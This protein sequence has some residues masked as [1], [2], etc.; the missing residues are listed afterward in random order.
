MRAS[1]S[2][3][4]IR[5]GVARFAVVLV[6]S[7]AL[8]AR[9][10]QFFAPAYNQPN[11]T[12]GGQIVHEKIPYQPSQLLVPTAA[13]ETPVYLDELAEPLE[14]PVLIDPSCDISCLVCEERAAGP[15]PQL[16]PGV[17]PGIFQKLFFTGA[18]QP[19]LEND[20][21]GWGDLETGIVLGLP[22]LRR[23]TPLVITPRFAVY[24]LD[25]PWMP[26]LPERLYDAEV[27]FR[28]LRRF[29]QGPWAMNVAVTLGHYSDWEASDADAFRVTGDAFAVY[30]Q[31]PGKKWV[32]GVIYL[33]REDIA[34]IPAA[35][36]IYEP[37]PDVKYEAILPRP[38]IAWRLPQTNPQPGDAR[39]FY[40]GGEFGSGIWSIERPLSLTQDLLTYRDLRV[41][42]GYERKVVGGL[43]R[44]FETGYV[45]DRELEF[46]SATPRLK[47]GDT[48]I[49]RV[50]V[51]Y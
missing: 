31:G 7:S 49:L 25:R 33:N 13:A 6:I 40:V 42:I 3:A 21:L 11:P 45:F 8:S 18:W 12:W 24:F 34:V 19:Q 28:H 47:L 38:R 37:T 50:G 22:C 26:D 20:S 44:R 4:P 10:Q 48:L 2:R 15:P 1:L 30:Q 39:W 35:G 27:E 16:A 36:L 29:G 23:E 51:T 41:L 9:G 32:L 43:S 5:R 17:R 46:S 14:T